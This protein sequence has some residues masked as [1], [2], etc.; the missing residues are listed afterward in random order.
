MCGDINPNP[1]PT[2]RKAYAKCSLCLMAIHQLKADKCCICG[3]LCHKRCGGNTGN[4]TLDKRYYTCA[5]CSLHQQNFPF[6]NTTIMD[7]SSSE[8]SVCINDTMVGD[9][10]ELNALET[11]RQENSSDLLLSHLNSNSIQNKFEELRHIVIESRVQ[12]MV[13]SETKVDASYPDS[14]FHIPGYHLHR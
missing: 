6:V 7:E 4:T 2:S 14:Q 10:T 1:G 12:I 8:N 9:T 3:L 11:A 5:S 13:G